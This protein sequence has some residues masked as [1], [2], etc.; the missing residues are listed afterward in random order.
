MSNRIDNKFITLKKEK[1]SALVSFVTAGDPSFQVSK[2]IISS[3]PKFGADLIEIGIPFSDPMADGPTIQRSSQRAIKSGINL[4]KTFEIVKSFRE[5]DQ[6]TPIILMGY[7]NPVFQFGLKDFF[8]TCKNVGVDG[9]I[10]VDLPPEEDNLII[11]F[12]EKYDVYN[13]RL[14]TPT[15]DK[16]R[17]K[18]ISKSS[19]GFLYYVSIMGIT[20]TKKPSLS[21]L[22]TSILNIKKITNLP[23]LAGFG[24]NSSDQVKQINKFA[25]GCVIGSAIIKIIEDSKKEN[26]PIKKILLKIKLFLSKIKKGN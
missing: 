16:K 18:K 24:I 6:N 10:I 14:V 23:I 25:D 17:L 4:N 9:L 8:K 11:S 12:T 22:K 13:I 3:L 5:I 21:S 2:K 1:K 26:Y 15:T 20:G 19:K 7:F